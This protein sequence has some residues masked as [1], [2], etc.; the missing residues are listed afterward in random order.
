MPPVLGFAAIA[1]A[2][3]CTNHPEVDQ[4][5]VR[6]LRCQQAF[7]PDCVVMLGGYWYCG[8][9]KDE[10]VRDIQSGTTTPFELASMGRRFVA[11]LLDGLLES[12]ALL[13]LMVPFLMLM[14][15]VVATSSQG[16]EPSE[17][18]SAVLGIGALGMYGLILFASIAVPLVYEALMVARRGQTVGKMAL[19][20]QVV[21]ADGAM[22]TRG[23]AWGRA[24][25]KVALAQFCS[26]LGLLADNLPAFFTP[27]KTT[28]HDMAVKTRVVRIR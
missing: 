8:P 3:Q 10:Q 4:E 16:G 24:A 14:A 18:A 9:C 17:A 7:C 23:Q 27:D 22:L 26:C 15:G 25:M 6:C 1:P 11:A 2:M 20:I 21:T 5:I 19:S 28:L 12:C 13:L